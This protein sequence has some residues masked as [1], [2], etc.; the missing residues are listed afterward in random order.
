ML[1]FVCENVEII[2][3]KVLFLV[4]FRLLLNL[5]RITHKKLTIE[6]KESKNI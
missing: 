2:I 6:M 5:K 3:N 4:L 1:D